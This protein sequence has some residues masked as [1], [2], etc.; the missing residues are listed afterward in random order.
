[1]LDFFS[2]L[3]LCVAL[4][5]LVRRLS[6]SSR[7]SSQLFLH[8]HVQSNSQLKDTTV[9]ELWSCRGM[10]ELW[11]AI[12]T[13]D[14]QMAEVEIPRSRSE[15]FGSPMHQSHGPLMILKA[16]Y[17]YFVRSIMIRARCNMSRATNKRSSQ[18]KVSSG[19]YR[20]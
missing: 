18:F 2:M 8:T 10:E 11:S 1:M 12:S 5:F 9:E 6:A 20:L 19:Q 4:P 3:R 14:G 16:R 17:S 7:D 13:N 15:T